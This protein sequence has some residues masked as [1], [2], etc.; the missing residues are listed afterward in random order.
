MQPELFQS[1]AGS[2]V[3]ERTHTKMG[4]RASARKI[5]RGQRQAPLNALLLGLSQ[6]RRQSHE[7]SSAILFGRCLSSLKLRSSLRR[8]GIA[9]TCG[10]MAARL[11]WLRYKCPVPEASATKERSSEE[12]A[13]AIVATSLQSYSASRV[14]TKCWCRTVG[15]SN[16]LVPPL[17]GGKF[18]QRFHCLRF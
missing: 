18:T 14:A 16:S 17:C 2:S 10:G 3:Q 6:H 9:N 5:L 11:I 8:P 4:S 1:A 12:R 7:V 15:Q 13:A